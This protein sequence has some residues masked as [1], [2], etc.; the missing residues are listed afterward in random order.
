MKENQQKDGQMIGRGNTQQRKPILPIT[1]FK[2]VPELTPNQ[3]MQIKTIMRH[4][5]TPK[6]QKHEKKMLAKMWVDR[7]SIPMEVRL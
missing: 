3:R 2:K 6:I 7:N 5:F 4:H 1:I